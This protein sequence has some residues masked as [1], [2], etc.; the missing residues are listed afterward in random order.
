[1]FVG[2]LKMHKSIKWGILIW[3]A[4]NCDAAEFCVHIRHLKAKYLAS[5]QI[6]IYEKIMNDDR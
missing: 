2:S 6:E 1:M 3:Y 5:Q 4:H